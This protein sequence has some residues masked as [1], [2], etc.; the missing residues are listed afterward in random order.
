MDPRVQ[1]DMLAH[2]LSR[3]LPRLPWETGFAGLVLGKRCAPSVT[4][5]VHPWLVPAALPVQ[6]VKEPDGLGAAP[7]RK[8]LRILN[9]G[10]S[11]DLLRSRAVAG[12]VQ[13]LMLDLDASVVGQSVPKGKE[14]EAQIEQ[15]VKE[16]VA[17]KATNTLAKRLGSL[18][19]YVR[20]CNEQGMNPLRASYQDVLA[21]VQELCQ[22]GAPTSAESFRG[23]LNFAKGTFQIALGEH[24]QHPRIRGMCIGHFLKKA[25]LKQ[26]PPLTVA[27]VK[28]LEALTADAELLQDKC[29]AG[30]MLFVL[31]SSC[32]FSDAQEIT[33]SNLDC[34]NQGHGIMLCE[35]SKH[36][37][38]RARELRG[39]LLPLMALSRGL[40]SFS[41]ARNWVLARKEAGL[42]FGGLP[43]LPPP[44]PAGGWHDR[45]LTASEGVIWLREL[46]AMKLQNLSEIDAVTTHSLKTTLL[47]WSA[48]FGMSLETR[49]ILGHHLDQG[50][51]STLTYSRDALTEAHEKVGAMLRAVIDGNFN[52][53][54]TPG[55]E[56]GSL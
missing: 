38:S 29:A 40:L 45:P 36:R 41:W 8:R 54:G 30:Y 27:M 5:S 23:A 52:P 1:A 39:R 9:P 10:P 49:R 31:Y 16:C 15:S 51:K 44:N 32:R 20:W 28:T 37:T 25:P 56:F 43:T 18:Q 47:A 42:E 19:R 22:T 11:P 35:V 21:Y 48:K 17:H 33:T 6:E 26:A 55:V 34:D 50:A 13:L 3:S 12:W 14:C 46:L 4:P 2:D 53:D 24:G 7:T